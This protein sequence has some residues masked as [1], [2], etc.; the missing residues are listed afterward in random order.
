MVVYLD[1]DDENYVTGY[2]SDDGDAKL[3][4]P[5]DHKFFDSVVEAW[6][7][8]D[9]ELI[10]DEERYSKI[11]DDKEKENS[12]LTPEEIN[13]MAILELAMVISEMKGGK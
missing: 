1:L 5:K 12:K 8:V 11:I 2:G 3:D 7:Y 4:L 9:G 10:F 6:K 13:E